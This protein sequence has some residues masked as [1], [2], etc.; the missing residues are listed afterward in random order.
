MQASPNPLGKGRSVLLQVLSIR[1][2]FQ[3]D[4][5]VVDGLVVLYLFLIVT[6]LSQLLSPELGTWK[7][8][9]LV[10]GRIFPVSVR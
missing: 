8:V 1:Q 4:D 2:Q 10:K 5:G 3:I 7:D 6:P 9:V